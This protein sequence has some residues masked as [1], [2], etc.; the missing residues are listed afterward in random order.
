MNFMTKAKKLYSI[1]ETC[2]KDYFSYLLT[3]NNDN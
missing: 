1:K 3:K 2:E